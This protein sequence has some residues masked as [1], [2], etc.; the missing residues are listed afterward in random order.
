MGR[1]G[2]ALS[3]QRLGEPVRVSATLP[4]ATALRLELLRV[5]LGLSRSGAIADA[6][7]VRTLVWEQRATRRQQQLFR[8]LW[9]EAEQFAPVDELF[10]RAIDV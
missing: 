10:A 8:R 1:D 6:V 4:L 5:E 9:R 3:W 7:A 2:L